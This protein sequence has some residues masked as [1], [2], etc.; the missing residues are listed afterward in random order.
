MKVTIDLDHPSELRKLRA[1]LMLRGLGVRVYDTRRGVH[2]ETGPIPITEEE[3]FRLRGLLGD[4]ETRLDLDETSFKVKH[5]LWNR[6]VVDGKRYGEEA[7]G[8][9]LSLPWFS[10]VPRCHYV[11]RR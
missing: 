8:D 1:Y 3:A 5:V 10:R 11:R 9:P 6:K 7:S 4:C 2:L